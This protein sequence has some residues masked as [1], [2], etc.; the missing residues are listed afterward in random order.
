MRLG[1][2]P[3]MRF[4][5]T[6]ALLGLFCASGAVAQIIQVDFKDAKA[7]KRYKKALALINGEQVLLGEPVEGGGFWIEKKDQGSTIHYQGGGDNDL[8]LLDVRDPSKIPY[9]INRKGEK[10]A[11]KKSSVLSVRG[12]DIKALRLF[13]PTETIETL[14]R[15]YTFRLR[16]IQDC[17]DA[18]DEHKRGSRPW[19]AAHHLLLGAYERTI[20]WLVNCSFTAAVDPLAKTLAKEKRQVAK[21]AITL[22]A[23]A[24]LNSVKVLGTTDDLQDAVEKTDDDSHVFRVQE[25]QHLR[26]VYFGRFSDERISDLLRLGE[27]VIELFRN[28]FVD[29]Y[30]SPDFEDRIPEGVFQEFYFGPSDITYHEHF[31]EAYYGFIWGD[32]A[33]KKRH[34]NSSGSRFSPNPGL[35]LDAWRV[36]E[37]EDM[38]GLITHGLGH[39]LADFHF[40]GSAAGMQQPWLEEGLGYYLSFELLGRNSVTCSAFDPGT[41]VRRAKE[42]GKKEIGMS[43]REMLNATA[44][45]YAPRIDRLLLK[46]L[47]AMENEDLAKSWSFLDYVATELDLTGQRWLRSCCRLARN[48]DTFMAELRKYTEELYGQPDADGTPSGYQAGKDVFD[49]LDKRWL[50]YAET[51]QISGADR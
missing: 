43:Y 32:D 20:N 18:R 26:V 5:I 42:E 21:E 12:K 15:E 31:V 40:H 16:R 29:P 33:N 45:E 22:R 13:Q 11:T 14:A 2:A 1:Y 38:E 48:R 24:A 30:V 8:Y 35:C 47:Y 17:E 7:A 25:S 9:K 6:L 28:Q 4:L 50:K 46:Y 23:E 51:E 10:E 27:K 36:P 49:F 34:R 37:R 19:F 44:R 3:L 41:Y 39:S